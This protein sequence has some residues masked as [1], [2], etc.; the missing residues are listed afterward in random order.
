MSQ[1]HPLRL[2]F[3]RLAIHNGMFELFNNGLVDGMALAAN[4]QRSPFL[5]RGT[6]KVFDGAGILL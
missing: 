1:A 2:M 3:D 4:Q 5:I 6:H